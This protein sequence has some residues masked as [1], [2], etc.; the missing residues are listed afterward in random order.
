MTIL[1]LHIATVDSKAFD[2][3]SQHFYVETFHVETIDRCLLSGQ[4]LVGVSEKHL[5]A[6]HWLC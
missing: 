2:S 5:G 4:D 6:L 3:Y 1:H